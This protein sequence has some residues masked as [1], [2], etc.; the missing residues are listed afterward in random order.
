MLK[1]N[2]KKICI[3]ASSL[4]KGGAER[5]SAN[6][7]KM[8]F[9][10]GYDVHIIT[11]LSGIDY[12][13]HGTLFNLGDF[14]GTNGSNIGR[15]NRLRL[16]K[17]YIKKHDFDL[18]I[19]N[20]SRLQAYREFIV[21][22]FIYKRPTVYVIHNHNVFK[23]FTKYKSLNRWLYKNQV[24]TAVS[25]A[26]TS[27]F[28]TLF[29]LKSISTIYNGFDF[30]KIQS[31]SDEEI[32]LGFSEAFIIF[33]GRIDDS[34]KNLRLLLDS[35]KLSDLSKLNIKL[36]ILGDGPDLKTLNEYAR[37]LKI[38][39]DVIF[40]GFVKNPYPYVKKAKFTVLTSRFEGFP[41]VIPESLC[42]KVPVVSVDCESGPN[43]V[44]TNKYNGIL[45]ENYNEAKLADAF[46]NLVL[47]NKLYQKCVSNSI[48][49]V[50]RFSFDAI[51]KSW[52][53]LIIT[54][55]K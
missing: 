32:D 51:M 2:K 41:M 21:S 55:I 3:V 4:T 40:K 6:L 13:Y 36:L 22:K 45:V 16:F 47:D 39:E 49:S 12:D 50:E 33:F 5:S 54:L 35:Y 29:N 46:N 53:Q 9:K 14:K 7:S 24:M 10:L 42:L 18:I 1:S 37:Q 17:S 44:I 34:H 23:S 52:E 19:D 8:L 25:K 31:E 20:R 26:A 48:D 38:H 28:K 15:L 27:K 43:E 11:V 30:E